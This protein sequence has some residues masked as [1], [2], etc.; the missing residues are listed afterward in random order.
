MPHYQ[1][2]KEK[3]KKMAGHSNK[4]GMSFS[5]LHWW[6]QSAQQRKQ[7]S[8]EPTWPHCG[9]KMLTAALLFWK[10]GGCFD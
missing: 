9:V 10:E 3:V 2:Q 5:S 1:M 8:R 7:Y 4:G 6:T